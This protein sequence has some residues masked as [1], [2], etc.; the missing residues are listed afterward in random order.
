MHVALFLSLSF[1]GQLKHCIDGS[2]L[3]GI[4]GS[5][6]PVARSSGHTYAITARQHTL[7]PGEQVL[8]TS[9]DNPANKT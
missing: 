8:A 7:V 5:C 1:S 3:L 6:N 9:F 2:R 4:A